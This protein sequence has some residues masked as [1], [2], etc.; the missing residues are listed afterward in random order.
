MPDIGDEDTYFT[1]FGLYVLNP[2]VFTHLE[3]QV[4]SG[5][6]VNGYFQLTPCIDRLRQDSGLQ[7][8]M[9]QGVRFD[10][11]SDATAYLHA[12][13]TFSEA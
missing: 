4:S 11:G 5:I 9:L 8:T 1:A 6:R 12:A 13:T 3:E 10:I 2:E 7:A